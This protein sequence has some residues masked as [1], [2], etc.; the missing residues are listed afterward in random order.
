MTKSIQTHPFVKV[1]EMMTKLRKATYN[2]S[3]MRDV[4]CINVLSI[5]LM[6]FV[7]G[8]FGRISV[9]FPNTTTEMARTTVVSLSDE[10]GHSD[11]G[12]TMFVVKIVPEVNC[13]N[14]C[15]CLPKAW[16][17]AGCKHKLRM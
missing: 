10:K 8:N 16:E 2:N 14:Q 11:I 9:E 4:I 13:N 15:V 3:E 12:S 17:R 1:R 6:T 7:S 5:S